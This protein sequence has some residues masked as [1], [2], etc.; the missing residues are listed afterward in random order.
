MARSVKRHLKVG[1][2]PQID[3]TELRIRMHDSDI[4]QGAKWGKWI[5][6]RAYDDHITARVYSNAMAEIQQPRAHQISINKHLRDKLGLKPGATV[7]FYVKKA[8][9]LKA[10]YYTARYHPTASVR[11]KALL[12]IL[13]VV[14]PL[15]AAAV[16][17]ALYFLVWTSPS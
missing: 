4:P 5:H 17:A 3:E 2:V 12:Q 7:D 16:I 6:L 10:P 11:R 13:G 8:S 14:V 9:G 1:G 15:V